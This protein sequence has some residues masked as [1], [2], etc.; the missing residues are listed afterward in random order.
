MA[1]RV[2]LLRSTTGLLFR[3]WTRGVNFGMAPALFGA[4]QTAAHVAS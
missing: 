2:A 1:D 4:R 3:V